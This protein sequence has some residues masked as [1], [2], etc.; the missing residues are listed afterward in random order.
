MQDIWSLIHSPRNLIVFEA[1]ARLGSFTKAADEMNMQQPSVSAAIKQLEQA[2]GVQ[3]FQRSHR[4]VT[5]T[6]AGERMFAG[7]SRGLSDIRTTAQE[8]RHMGLSEHVTL[9]TSSAF[10]YYWMMPRMAD[11]HA[12]HPEIDLRLQSSDREP[13][14]DAENISLAIRLGNG[15]WPG[16]HSVMIA[17][18]II[19]PV[20]NP[21]VMAAAKNLRSIPNLMN[22]RLIQF[23]NCGEPVA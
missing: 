9:S 14:L 19:Y 1:A 4:R 10:S 20:A 15:N 17:E 18:E 3:L 11:L 7:V 2:L 12:T 21:R 23:K 13:D 8:V 16:Y 6:A 5:L 22:E